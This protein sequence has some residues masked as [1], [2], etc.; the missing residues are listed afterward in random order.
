MD[1][2]PQDKHQGADP[3]RQES[4][5]AALKR[6]PA[7]SSQ[8]VARVLGALREI[9]SSIEKQASRS[10][11]Q[12]A[13]WR[14]PQVEL[15]QE[16]RSRWY[17]RQSMALGETE[18]VPVHFELDETHSGDDAATH[19]R[20]IELCRSCVSTFGTLA[21]T[22]LERERTWHSIGLHGVTR[23]GGF[24]FHPGRYSRP[25]ERLAPLMDRWVHERRVGRDEVDR[26][27]ETVGR[28]Q[29]GQRHGDVEDR[30]ECRVHTIDKADHLALTAQLVG[31]YGSK[32]A[33]SGWPVGVREIRPKATLVQ[34]RI[35][36]GL[37]HEIGDARR[38]DAVRVW[39]ERNL[40]ETSWHA[41]IHAPDSD[42]DPRNHVAYVVYTQ[43]RLERWRDGDGA[44]TNHWRFEREGKLPS[45]APIVAEL[46]GKGPRGRMGRGELIRRWRADLAEIQNE[47]LG[48]VGARKRYDARSNENRRIQRFPGTD[49]AA[50]S[51][52][53]HRM[54]CVDDSWDGIAHLVRQMV[55]GGVSGAGRED[56]EHAPWTEALEALRLF[57]GIRTDEEGAGRE[58][59]SQLLGD[60]GQ[61]MAIGGACY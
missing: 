10:Q 16:V 36:M 29:V 54:G 23:R 39:C 34:R 40:A 33:S 32:P 4:V 22:A 43:F 41:C 51:S 60:A 35:L 8:T 55:D 2:V 37:A 47:H 11:L 28:L 49:S 13:W 53:E 1:D 46:W 48:A 38:E 12:A 20:H 3:A 7:P 5:D 17:E 9:P 42:A 57:S 45:P 6:F 21:E 25:V 52:A 44:P 56:E 27:T 61:A 24:G 19:Q 14:S 30:L 50:R 18:A 59:T 58:A 15:V 31:L 26:W